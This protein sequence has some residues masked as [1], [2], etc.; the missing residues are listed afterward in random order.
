MSLHSG[1]PAW[2]NHRRLQPP[3]LQEIVSACTA[4]TAIAG[5]KC[6][7]ILALATPGW[8]PLSE[9]ARRRL[10]FRQLSDFLENLLLAL[11][12]LC[13]KC[14][15]IHLRPF[16]LWEDFLLFFLNMMIYVFTENSKFRIV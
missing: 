12:Y 15:H 6:P 5:R 14:L 13:P 9:L 4:W 8:L 3:S 7:E 16:R 11:L 2:A 10:L 1:G